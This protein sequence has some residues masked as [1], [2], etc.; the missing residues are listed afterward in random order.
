MKA[1]GDPAYAFYHCISRVVDRR[2]VLGQPQ[3]DQ[4]LQFMREYET[5]CG[6]GVRPG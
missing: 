3:K 5:F 4:F 6:V 2:F 1:P